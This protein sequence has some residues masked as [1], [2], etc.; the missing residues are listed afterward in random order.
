MN[1]LVTPC[2]HCGLKHQCLCSAIPN[3][4]SH[5]EVL[6]LTHRNEET[7]DTNTGKLLLQTLKHSK[8]V[9]WHRGTPAEAI[10]ERLINKDWQPVVLFPHPEGQSLPMTTFAER[11]ECRQL[12]F[13]IID[14]TW[15]EAKK[16]YRKTPWL[17]ALPHLEL[18]I[19]SISNYSL[20][21][22]QEQGHLCTCEV[23]AEIL[24]ELGEQ[25]QAQQLQDYF[26]LY[27]KAFKADKSGHSLN[28]L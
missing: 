2:P 15:Q 27:L 21:R 8:K 14:A 5:C 10:D 1:Q 13:I 6:L 20:R 19:E 11:A 24:A 9:I 26:E 16:I 25:Q 23:G 22:N 12:L 3:L 17:Q 7:R 28:K 18:H 4:D